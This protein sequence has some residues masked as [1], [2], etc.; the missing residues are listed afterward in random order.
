MKAFLS[1]TYIDLIEHRK[2][3]AE[4]LERL[5][6]EVGRMEV[7]GARPEEATKACFSEIEACDIF[8][9][10]Y[11]HRYGY[12]PP[13]TQISITE[14][15]YDHAIEHKK[16]MFC[17][18]VDEDYPWPPKMIEEHP[19][20]FKF[21]N[22]KQRIG[23][24]LVRD[25]FT[26]PEVLAFKIASSIGR[27]L[28]QLNQASP[29]SIRK[30]SAHQGFKNF[31]GRAISQTMAMLFVDI[32]R[33]LY[34]ASS[35]SV[36]YANAGRFPEFIDVADQHFG[37]LRSRIAAYSLALNS[38]FLE[39][40][41]Q[42]ELNLSWMLGR[43]K[44]KPNLSSSNE[45]YFKRMRL[46]GDGLNSFCTSNATEQYKDSF[47]NVVAK[48]NSTLAGSS[49]NLNSLDDVLRL[50]LKAQTDLLKAM[51]DSN[52]VRIFTIADD[53]DQKIA[54]LYFIIDY[55]LLKMRTVEN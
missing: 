52:G 37:D 19:G 22:F 49:L 1:S 29:N 41:N 12:V 18:M 11:A 53:M 4:V 54:I 20:K 55:V 32:M 2:L 15:E 16:L 8:V 46:I 27:Y 9:G 25:T 36:N 30:D 21:H 35:D 6:Q 43:L 23:E 51:S 38:T 48:I 24:F 26:S 28:T 45:N 31:A 3:A 34:L 7:F 13:G 42:L 17:F 40:I 10:I 44:R 33:L 5:G 14:A 47:E 39:Q 50:R